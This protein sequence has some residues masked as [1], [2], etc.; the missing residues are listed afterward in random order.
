L[1]GAVLW[2]DRHSDAG[3]GEK[4]LIINMKR[5]IKVSENFTG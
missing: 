2:V 4:F 1:G 3:R 5:L